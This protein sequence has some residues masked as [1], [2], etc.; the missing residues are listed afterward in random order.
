MPDRAVAGPAGDALATEFNSTPRLRYGKSPTLVFMGK[1]F[2]G[3][4]LGTHGYHYRAAEGN[5]VLY[6]CR[7]GH[8][9]TTHLRIA[10]DWTAH[11]AA[12][13]YK[14]LLRG[15]PSFSFRM[16]ADRHSPHYVQIAYPADWANLS[17]E[18]RR[19]T[20]REVALTMGPYLAYTLVTWHEILTW[21]GY[22]SVGFVPEFH[23][24]FSWED[25]FSNLLGTYL[26]AKALR[27]TAHSYDQAMTIVLDEEVRKLGVQPAAVAKQASA[28]VQ[29]KWYSGSIGTFINMKKRGLDIG[30]ETGYATPILV[31]N[32]P[33][34]PG[35]Q[36]VPYPRPRSGPCRTTASR[37][38]S[39]SSRTSG[40]RTRFSAS[41]IRING[42]AD[43][44]PRPISRR[45]CSTSAGKRPTGMARKRPERSNVRPSCVRAGA[46][47]LN[48]ESETRQSGC[49]VSFG[50]SET[51]P[52]SQ[53]RMTE[54]LSPGR[55]LGSDPELSVSGA[56]F[57]VVDES[58][59]GFRVGLAWDRGTW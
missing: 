58:A 17:Q 6:T 20:A 11:L 53:A 35:A 46:E 15:D 54:T 45:S 21:Y 44:C 33:S 57:G 7:A 50:Q 49:P 32:V 47:T 1:Q 18:Q 29:Y 34:C 26:A 9:D 3:G 4:D 39:R 25:S 41:S 37:W 48:S 13:S 22:R 42:P 38:W 43:S 27:D 28:S 2:I 12:E 16:I 14:H 59:L 19:H 30:V 56:F 36:P 31:P 51:S 5:G 8:I 40:R 10:A 52:K 55:R 23:S 24:S